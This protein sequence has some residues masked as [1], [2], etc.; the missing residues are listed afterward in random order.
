LYGYEHAKAHILSDMGEMVVQRLLSIAVMKQP[1]YGYG[2]KIV[3]GARFDDGMLHIGVF[4]PGVFR[5]CGVAIS[6]FTV[7]NRFGRFQVST[8]LKIRLNRPLS[9][10]IDGDYGW[11]DYEFS[12]QVLRGALKI[13]V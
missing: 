9:L 13:K 11:E 8:A 6:A 5:I 12:F 4:N 3:P 2:M 10:Q 7:G 1:Y